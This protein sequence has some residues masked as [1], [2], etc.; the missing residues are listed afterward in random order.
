MF[1]GNNQTIFRKNQKSAHL[2]FF[3]GHNR[4]VTAT[5]KI[6]LKKC[7]QNTCQKH[8][9]MLK[10]NRF[11]PKWR[12]GRR[13]GLKIPR[14]QLHVGS[15]P[16]FGTIRNYKFYFHGILSPMGLQTP[17]GARPRQVAPGFG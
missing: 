8:K 17:V 11:M 5:H 10:Y 2:L 12:N 3:K 7:V 16:T 4:V 1:A 6:E 14:G 9:N 13:T 15:T